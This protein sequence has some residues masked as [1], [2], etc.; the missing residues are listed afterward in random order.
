MVCLILGV[1]SSL[2][3]GEAHYHAYNILHMVYDI[4]Y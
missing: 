3:F 4:Q 2:C 1:W